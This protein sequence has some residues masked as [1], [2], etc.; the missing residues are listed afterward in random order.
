MKRIS[1]NST[2]LILHTQYINLKDIVAQNRDSEKCKVREIV[3]KLY[4]NAV[5]LDFVVEEKVDVIH[6][7]YVARQVLIFFGDLKIL[8]LNIPGFGPFSQV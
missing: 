5:F 2:L 6:Q 3:S 7:K 4:K 8:R 1:A